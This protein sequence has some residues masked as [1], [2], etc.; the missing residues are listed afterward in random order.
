MHNTATK[1]GQGLTWPQTLALAHRLMLG[2]AWLNLAFLGLMSVFRLVLFVRFAEWHQ[3]AGLGLDILQA[4][5]L[6]MRF[7]LAALCAFNALLLLGL[8]A[9]L[10]FRRQNLLGGWRRFAVVYWT[11][12]FMAFSVVLGGDIGFYSYFQSHYNALIFGLWEDDTRALLAIFWKNYP[13]VMILVGGLAYGFGV[14]RLTR[15]CLRP[16]LLLHIPAKP[17]WPRGLNHLALPVI[18]VLVLIGARGSLG[19]HPLNQMHTGLSTNLFLNQVSYS[20]LQSLAVAFQN[21]YTVNTDQTDILAQYGYKNN[22][23]QAFADYLGLPPERLKPDLLANLVRTTPVNPA[24]HSRPPHVVFITMESF[25]AYWLRY[26]SPSFDLLG[27]LRPHFQRDVVFRHFT[28]GE[29]STLHSILA[30]TLSL[31]TLRANETFTDDRY[32]QTMF[33]SSMAWPFKQQGYQTTYLYGGKTGWRDIN[34]FFPR[35]GF[36][37]VEG[38][39]EILRTLKLEGKPVTHDWGVFDEYQLDYLYQ[40]LA[41]AKRPQF[42]AI[43]TTTNH[44]PYEVP[45]DYHPLPLVM[46]AALKQRITGDATLVAQRFVAYQYA[47]HKLGQFIARIKASPLRQDTLIAVTG[48]HNFGGVVSFSTAESMDWHAVPLYLYIPARLRPK[49]IN[50][51]VFGSHIDIAPT[52][53]HLALSNQPYV[54]VGQNLLNPSAQHL[55]INGVVSLFNPQGAALRQSDGSFQY[56]AWEQGRLTPNATNPAALALAKYYRA[57]ASVSQYYLDETYKQKKP[58]I[59]P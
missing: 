31:P 27:D 7:D 51:Q 2:L 16:G 30:E 48:D 36:D 43:M 50:T 49:H 12:L 46:P 41:Q 44:P 14:W 32:Q 38:E 24:A 3:F 55:A 57:A 58:R 10:P 37:R 45:A 23:R 4:F 5:W 20:G 34:T 9:L 26:D 19:L 42:I 13:L 33:T 52:L 59:L 21:H 17:F 56:F 25:G 22:M 40:Q 54:A 11:V 18:L 35:Q 8:Y 39:V 53:F 28:S 1:P 29:N 6:G 15:S 47:N